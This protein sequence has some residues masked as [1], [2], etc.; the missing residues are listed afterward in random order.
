MVDDDFDSYFA[1]YVAELADKR[2]YA[3]GLK[4]IPGKNKQHEEAEV[5]Q[6][7]LRH[8]GI[9]AEVEPSE[10]PDNSVK[11]NDGRRIGIEIT[12]LV[13]EQMFA[14]HL[15]RRK[16]ERKKDLSPKESLEA[17]DAAFRMARATSAEARANGG[18]WK[19]I[20]ETV[21]RENHPTPDHISP[22]E[23][24]QWDI[25][26]LAQE[27]DNRIRKKDSKCKANASQYDEI[28]LAIFTD[29]PMLYPAMVSE[30]RDKLQ[31]HPTIIARVFIVFG[32]DPAIQGYPVVEVPSY[33]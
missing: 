19:Q 28:W 3:W 9:E 7:V 8:L 24:A 2:G 23:W 11:T 31:F 6:I 17:A 10:A 18:D 25:T 12:W 16:A 26:K 20:F 4:G 29:E 13:D 14:L 1:A 5:A 21:Y 22:Y 32:Y 33:G 30:A 15:E 27:L